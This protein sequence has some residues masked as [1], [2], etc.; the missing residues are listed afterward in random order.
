M[1]STPGLSVALPSVVAMADI[2][3]LPTAVA[4]GFSAEELAALPDDA[5]ADQVST[6][7]GR[8]AAGEARLIALVA[9]VD[10]REMWA[11]QGA[12][13]CAHW[14]SW[15]L[16]MR[17]STAYSKVRVA[18]ALRELPKTAAAFAAGQLSFS[19]VREIA[20]V[21][22]ASDEDTWLGLARCATGAQL[23]KLVR[24]V[25]RA[26]RLA[27]DAADP[28]LADYRMRSS[29][30]YHDD[31]TLVIMVRVHAEEGAVV[32]AA[33][34]QARAQLEKAW[35]Q[36][37]P[38]EEPAGADTGVAESS[39]G[40]ASAPARRSPSW[41][42]GLLAV[43]REFLA[44]RATADGATITAS[45]RRHARARLLV[46]L[47]PLSGWGRL[48]DGEFLPPAVMTRLLTAHD[49]G[50]TSREVSPELRATLG[51]LD[52]ERCRFPSCTRVRKL[53]GHH[54][55]Y[56]ENGGATDLANLVLLCS[57]HHT[58]VHRDGYRLALGPDRRLT[59]ATK[60]G[61][62]L[63]HKPDLPY[64]DAAGLDPD[65]IIDAATLPPA[66]TDS[67]L[68]LHYAVSVLTQQAA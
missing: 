7:A 9:E 35:G 5:L 57:R 62:P 51:V 29:V 68:N 8:V 11:A 30:S 43:S 36:D 4:A 21:A 38:A 59:V 20:R 49:R 26:R 63:P 22:E 33:V 64:G 28:Q 3:S 32:L 13:S 55:V 14:L 37:S 15:K 24:G 58:L 44:L 6:W 18:R 16:G 25:R 65:G 12:L 54:V 56:W 48:A 17:P 46:Q 53:H 47:D 60:D 23:G 19:Q 27:E 41:A 67:R 50:R 2:A 34:E 66:V 52:G 39:D 31:G 45:A 40:K 42:E 10:R 1:R 61:T